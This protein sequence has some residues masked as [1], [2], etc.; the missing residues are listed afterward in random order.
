MN[1]MKDYEVMIDMRW[2]HSHVPLKAV[3]IA[4][5]LQPLGVCYLIERIVTVIIPGRRLQRS[6]L[7]F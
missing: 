7:S 5:L 6:E 1:V 3:V 2:S 4:V